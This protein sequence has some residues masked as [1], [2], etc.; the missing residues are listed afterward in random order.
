MQGFRGFDILKRG[1]KYGTNDIL[2]SKF[3]EHD[4]NYEAWKEIWTE[5]SKEFS[6]ATEL[7]TTGAI[8]SKKMVFTISH[9]LVSFKRKMLG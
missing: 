7:S 4:E 6:E 2:L 9:K 5:Y 8:K 3:K 1:G